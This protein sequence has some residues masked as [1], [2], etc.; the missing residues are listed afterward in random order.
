[1]T[2]DASN[3]ESATKL[4]HTSG[5]LHHPLGPTAAVVLH[6]RL[7]YRRASER[8]PRSSNQRGRDLL[9]YVEL[10]LICGARNEQDEP[11]RVWAIAPKLF[12]IA[13]PRTCHCSK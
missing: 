1:M 4:D 7:A 13:T 11:L 9:A 6:F 10:T 5:C 12:Q 8:L 3:S 2:R